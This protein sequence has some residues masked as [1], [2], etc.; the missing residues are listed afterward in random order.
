[1]GDGANGDDVVR[2]A[3]D[4]S[5]RPEDRE[6][7]TIPAVPLTHVNKRH[8]LGRFS[9]TSRVKAK[10]TLILPGFESQVERDRSAINAGDA[11]WDQGTATWSVE[12]RVYGDKGTGT[13]YPISGPGFVAIGRE[14]AV[15]LAVFKR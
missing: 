8:Y 6:K 11:R 4:Q 2:V 9:P 7:R 5:L 13:F 10:T 3:P 12:D 15:L 14:V 1:M